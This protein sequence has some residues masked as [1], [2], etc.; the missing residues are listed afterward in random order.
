MDFPVVISETSLVIFLLP[1]CAV[2]CLYQLSEQTVKQH[3]IKLQISL[4]G[5]ENMAF[6]SKNMP[7]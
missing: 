3:L 7:I 6:F 5:T 1:L 2:E 4:K